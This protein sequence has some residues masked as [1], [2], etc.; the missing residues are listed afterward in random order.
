MSIIINI[1]TVVLCL[2]GVIFSLVYIWLN[3]FS[4]ITDLDSRNNSTLKIS[5]A[6]MV[7][8]L[9][10]A[11]LSCFL[12]APGNIGDAISRSSKLYSFIAVSW[13]IVI[14]GCGISMLIA[15]VSKTKYREGL[16]ISVKKIFLIALAG[17]ITGLLLA[18]L[19]S[20]DMIDH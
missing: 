20:G 13:L 19:L 10:F 11:L 18:W 3:T 4:K 16:L 1:S 15:L 7:L 6:S 12:S 2:S 8:S 5:I 14:L 9:I 17:S